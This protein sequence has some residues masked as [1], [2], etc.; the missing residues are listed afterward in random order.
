MAEVLAS[1]KLH[2][3]NMLTK[4]KKRGIFKTFLANFGDP[5]LRILLIAL[6]IQVVFVFN[7]GQWIETLGIAL[8]IFVA[9]TVSTLSEYGSESAFEKLQ[10]QASA[11][12]ARA[13]RDGEVCEIPVSEV[14]VGDI[15]MLG[16]GEKIPAD[17]RLVQGHLEVDQSLLNG[18]SKEA[19]KTV[20]NGDPK[21][22]YLCPCSLFSGTVVTSGEGLM[23]VTGV[24]DKTEYGKIAGEL[25]EEMPTSPLKV[26]L[27]GLAKVI[28]LFGYIGAGLVA[29]A[30]FLNLWLSGA[31][32]GADFPFVFEHFLRAATLVVAVIVMSVPEGLP[33]MIT[34]VLSSNVKFMLRDNVLVRKLN[35]IE[36]AGSMNI[37]FTDKTGTLTHG[38][39]EVVGVVTGTGEFQQLDKFDK[40]SELAKILAT[41]LTLNTQ[42]ELTK[43]GKAVG[44]NSTDRILLEFAAKFARDR[45]TRQ[46]QT[47]FNSRDKF[48]STILT[49]GRVLLKGAYEVLAPRIRRVFNKNGEIKSF[50]NKPKLEKQ[51]QELSAQAHR[52]LAVMIDDVLVGLVAIRDQVRPESITAVNRLT[53]AGIQTVMITGDA[54]ETAVAIAREVG[55]LESETASQIVLTSDEL[56]KLS[57]EELKK[58]LPQLKVVAR[59]LPSD[60]SRL[61]RIA[62]SLNLVAGMTGD[63]VNDAPALKK[64]DIGF[65]MG[66]GTE[67]AKEA[68]DIV[69]MD[70]NIDSISKG[71]SY[72]R[73]IFKSIRKFLI[74]K[75]TINFCAVAV[76]ILAPLLNIDTPITVIQM[77]WINLV[78]DTLAGLAF[79]G[80]RPREEYMRESPKCRTESII[81]RHMWWQILLTGAFTAMISLWF[82][83]SH[84]M[85]QI[86]L[87]R[88]PAYALTVFFAFFMLINI[89]N[90]FN[91]RTHS[92]NL[93][94]RLS[95]NKPFVW[96]MGTVTVIQI[97][98]IY[99]GGTIFRTVPLDILHLITVALLALTVVPFDMLRKSLIRKD[100]DTT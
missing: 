52:I 67:V 61:V 39:L 97:T 24:G 68:G 98:I 17:G 56:S 71:V 53:E 50:T 51:I 13:R 9:V 95:R 30:Y 84:Y 79:G 92:M 60:K 12:M 23:L 87:A 1:R 37:L 11:I 18:E 6:G 29:I 45:W 54:K 63:G 8:A 62:Q 35:G 72:G 2:G 82:L 31:L 89:L 28:S 38:K 41:S 43:A 58:I 75:L 77:L 91:A 20:L 40:R 19:K 27:Q 32:V 5:M 96:I 47:P 88:G 66:S 55:I 90:S 15:V 59:A 57:D 69:I 73:T 25:Q 65:A 3:M 94:S 83:T 76:S 46:S 21:L 81:N 99:I 4:R 26:K 49:D 78:M 48:M 93:F 16:T 80:E 100:G 74:F 10:E 22:D 34:V 86:R 85:D 14:V 44:G 70:D 7:S 33:L 36:T 42:S 64:A